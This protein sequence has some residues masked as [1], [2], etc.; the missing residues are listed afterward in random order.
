M[1]RLNLTRMGQ[2]TPP[3]DKQ[4]FPGD[5]CPVTGC[6]GHFVVYTT[7]TS[8]EFRLRYLECSVCKI[9]PEDTPWVTPIED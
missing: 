1:R 8:G 6:I 2:R 3:T 4:T 9:K 5:P 7:R